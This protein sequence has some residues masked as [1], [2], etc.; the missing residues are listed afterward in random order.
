M[1]GV[2]LTDEIR[3]AREQMQD[4]QA[5][6]LEERAKTEVSIFGKVKKPSHIV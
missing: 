3:Q 5:A 1:Q 4:L 6:L 2:S